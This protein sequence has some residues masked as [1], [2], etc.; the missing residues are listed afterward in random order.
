VPT[1]AP[2]TS[3]EQSPRSTFQNK[4]VRRRNLKLQRKSSRSMFDP[5]VFDPMASS[6]TLDKTQT[7][8]FYV[9][10]L[11]VAL[12]TIKE[13]H[14]KEEKRK[15]QYFV[16]RITQALCI[17]MWPCGGLK[18]RGTRVPEKNEDLQHRL[19][20]FKRESNAVRRKSIYIQ[21]RASF[22]SQ[23]TAASAEMGALNSSSV[24]MLPSKAP[25]LL[26]TEELFPEEDEKFYLNHPLVAELDD[27]FFFKSRYAYKFA[28]HMSLM[29]DSFYLAIWVTNLIYIANHTEHPVIYNL[30]LF[31]PVVLMLLLISYNLI[32][33]SVV[34]SVTSLRNKGSEWICEQD[35]IKRKVLPV[36][37]AEV[38]KLFPD[39]SKD[40]TIEKLYACIDDDG[41]NGINIAEFSSFLHT[42]DI[43]PPEKEI[44]ALFRAMDTDGRCVINVN[45]KQAIAIRQ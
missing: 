2:S 30:I 5:D 37:R 10:T 1:E 20:Q 21:S 23:M 39:I 26:G 22:D 14:E 8:N 32:V 31:L 41:D 44:R 33:S 36:L 27:I 3:A 6:Y 7:E 45:L 13:T 9:C 38:S 25:G 12:E 40:G 29:L 18:N 24:D 28:V 4:A 43:H 17:C 15:M 11:R 16:H 42:L 19:N 34:L 35:D